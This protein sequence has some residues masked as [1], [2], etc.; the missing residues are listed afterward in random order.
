M[1][2]DSLLKVL[3]L[4]TVVL[5]AMRFFV[6]FLLSALPVQ[7]WSAHA[8]AQFG[9]PKYPAG[10]RHFDYVNPDAPKGGTLTLSLVS[11][12]SSFDKYNPFTLKG[13]PAPGLLE[14]LFETLTV[15]SLD[16]PN[17]QYGLLAEDIDLAP[18]LRSVTFRLHPLAHFSN[19]DPVTADDVA[20]SFRTL[21]R[22]QG[23]SP[24]FKAYFSEIEKVTVLDARHIRFE[25]SRPGKDLS[26]VAGSVPVF[27]QKWGLKADGSR[28]P[29]ETLALEPPI[30]TGAYILESASNGLSVVYRRDPGYWGNESPARRGFYNF[31]KVI[32]KLYKDRDTQVT[33]LRAGD[34]DFYSETQMRYWCCQYIGKRFDTGELVKVKLP[35]KNPPSMNGWVVNLRRP[36]F[37]DPRVR[38]A[39]NYLLDFEWINEKILDNEFLRTDSYFAGTPLQASGLPSPEE[40]QLLEPWRHEL[41]PAVFGPAYEQPNSIKAGG[42]RASLRRALQLFA[43]AGWHYRDGYLR[44]DNGEPLTLEVSGLRSQ[45]AHVETVNLNL[46]KAGILLRRRD[47]DPATSQKRM[48]EFD[49]DYTSLSLRESRLPAGELWRVFNSKDADTPGSENIIG[50]KSPAV[51]ALIQQLMDVDNQHDFEVTGRALDRVLMHSHYFIPFRYLD[52][53]YVVHHKHLRQPDVLPSY[54]N[55]QEW[56]IGTWWDDPAT[57][58]R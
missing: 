4:K 52:H 31:D 19:G 5:K 3:V 14:M 51:D 26:F 47:A 15:F 16:E 1:I 9:E 8:I 20:H 29:F 30:S 54:Y 36:Q 22:G 28:I 10:F 24:R 33:A 2:R 42:F 55:A 56:A 41:P 40:L 25:F 12:N 58:P 44:N 48:R 53:H 23:V 6:L 37:Q 21:A 46:L 45:S 50:V 34:Y 17:T 39:L 49:F 35:H 18:D 7:S 11:L 13:R 27:S 32:Y 57:S 38:E 43:E